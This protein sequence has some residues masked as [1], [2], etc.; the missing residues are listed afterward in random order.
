MQAE[1]SEAGPSEAGEVRLLGPFELLNTGAESLMIPMLPLA[2]VGAA[3]CSAPL[4]TQP[5]SP[6]VDLGSGTCLRTTLEQLQKPCPTA[7]RR[8]GTKQGERK[9]R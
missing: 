4:K 2:S 8:N 9:Q 1:I 7:T 6:R 3:V 5:F